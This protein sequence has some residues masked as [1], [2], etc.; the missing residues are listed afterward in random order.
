MIREAG[1]IDAVNTAEFVRRWP[2][3]R[4]NYRMMMSLLPI[5]KLNAL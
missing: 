5:V 1:S 4:G 3:R 2:I